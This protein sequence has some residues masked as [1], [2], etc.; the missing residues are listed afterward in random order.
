[1]IHAQG[2]LAHDVRMLALG[3]SYTIG[4]SV[5]ADERWPVRLASRLRSTGVSV[6]DPV[7]VARTGW[8]TDELA[9][10]IDA[11]PPSGTFGLVTLLV[12]VNNQYRGRSTDEYRTQFRAVLARAIAFADAHAPRVIVVSI[13]DWGVTPFAR[14]S[15]RGAARIATE[16]DAFNAIARDEALHAGAR[17]LDVTPVSRRAALDPELVA[18]DGLHPSGV[19]YE[20]WARLLLP[21]ALEVVGKGPRR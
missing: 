5:A 6:A 16:I 18:S 3:D 19:M 17:F 10:G 7:I 1:V 20:E 13:P 9:K 14:R 4:E 12:G 2:E 15:G 8:T 21:V 11:T